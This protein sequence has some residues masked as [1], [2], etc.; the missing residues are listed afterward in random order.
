M[1]AISVISERGRKISEFKAGQP[2]L[3]KPCLKKKKK[4][5]LLCVRL[6]CLH[7]SAP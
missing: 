7:V 1:V 4:K 2:R 5:E 3:P 6:F